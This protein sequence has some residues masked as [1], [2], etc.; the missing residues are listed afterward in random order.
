MEKWRCWFLPGYLGNCSC[1]S[2]RLLAYSGEPGKGFD[3]SFVAVCAQSLDQDSA[4][5]TLR[6]F[7]AASLSLRSRRRFIPSGACLGT[8]TYFFINMT[9]SNIVKMFWAVRCEVS[10]FYCFFFFWSEQKGASY[11]WAVGVRRRSQI[12][13]RNV[14]DAFLCCCA[15]KIW[16]N[17][18]LKVFCRC[19]QNWRRY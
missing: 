11:S 19:M 9:F 6:Y 16:Q 3:L 1:S 10:V 5:D 8:L 2:V 13:N 7:F 15:W 14:N 18:L 4:R 12:S 17:V